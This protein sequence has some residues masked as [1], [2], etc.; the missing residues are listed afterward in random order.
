MRWVVLLAALAAMLAPAMAAPDQPT[1]PRYCGPPARTASGAIARSR[2]AL[3]VFRLV[4]PCPATG[5]TGGACPGWAVDHVIPLA[6]GGCDSIGNMQWL[7]VAAKASSAP[8]AKDRFER[9]IY[10]R[11]AAGASGAAP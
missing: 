9:V 2:P 5:A 10:C 7:P 4:H 3:R 1:D 11:P 8:T 6:C